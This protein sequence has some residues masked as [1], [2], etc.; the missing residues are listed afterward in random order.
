MENF[1]NAIK[2]IIKKADK[3]NLSLEE[4]LDIR[5][6]WQLKKTG[7]VFRYH[8]DP[9]HG[10]IEVEKNVLE[11]LGISCFISRCSY[12]DTDKNLAYL[13]EDCD[14]LIFSVA[15]VANNFPFYVVL[16]EVNGDSEIRNLKPFKF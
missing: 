6:N 2:A 3:A 9:S 10:W 8:I 12:Q 13:E 7:K 16:I 14:A 15:C 4:I 5:E 1:S 11:D